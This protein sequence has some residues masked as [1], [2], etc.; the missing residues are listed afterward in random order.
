M[1]AWLDQLQPASFRGVP[2]QVDTIEHQAGDNVVVRE[3]P[4]QD[5]PTV[6]RM[7]EGIEEIKFS[8]YV[9]GDDYIEQRR[10]LREVLTGSGVLIHPTAGSVR[11]FVAGKYTVKEAPTAEGG[12]ARFDLVFVRAETRRYPTGVA[13]TSQTAKDKATAAKAASVDAFAAGFD[14]TNKPGWVADRVVARI[15]DSVSAVWGNMSKVTGGLGDFSN[16]VIGNYQVLR[17][18]VSSLVRQPRLLGNAVANLFSLPTDLS[19]AVARD[20][21]AN[22]G[23]LFNLSSLVSNRDFEVSSMPAVGAGLV[24]Y[25]TGNADTLGLATPARAQLTTLS[26]TSDQLF[27]TLALAGWVE[28]IAASDMTSYDDALTLRTTV[29]DQAVRLLTRSSCQAAPDNP[30][31]SAWHDA[32]LALMTASLADIAD[33]SRDLVRLTTFTPDAWTPV[34]LVSYRLF[35]TAAYADEILDMNPHIEHP[36]LVPP[37]IPL[38][39]MR[40]D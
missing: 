24:M 5:L 7:S 20:F 23:G 18:G 36:L 27:E 34:W 33:R 29:N 16:T 22:F 32:T 21:S 12:M 15:T 28:A 3:Y 2:F 26:N 1:P 25:G 13:N 37:G 40:H 14:L 30:P 6:F 4:F 10:A 11:V 31:E 19:S 35:G 39:V 9:I 38:R 17:D 8:A